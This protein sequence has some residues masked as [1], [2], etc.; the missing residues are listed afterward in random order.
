MSG[1]GSGSGSGG[2]GGYITVGGITVQIPYVDPGIPYAQE[3]LDISFCAAILQMSS[4]MSNGIVSAA[5]RS[6]ATMALGLESTQLA[7]ESNPSS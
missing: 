2:D 7:Q 1:S 4:H 6:A 3:I 5:I